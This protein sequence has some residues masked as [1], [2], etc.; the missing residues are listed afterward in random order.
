M[1]KDPFNYET[2]KRGMVTC[3]PAVA[4]T[5]QADGN[6]S[7]FTDLPLLKLP[8]ETDFFLRRTPGVAPGQNTGNYSYAHAQIAQI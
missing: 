8:P 5:V 3:K 2:G 6:N 7:S 1:F 4:Y